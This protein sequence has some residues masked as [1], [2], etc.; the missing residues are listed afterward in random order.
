MGRHGVW[1]EG[2]QFQPISRELSA[3]QCGFGAV[4]HLEGRSHLRTVALTAEDGTRHSEH[5]LRWAFTGIMK[6]IVTF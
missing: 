2:N 4:S 5:T 6:I 3:G 1:K